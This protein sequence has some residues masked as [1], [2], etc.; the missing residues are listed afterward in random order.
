[1]NSLSEKAKREL[2]EALE[3]KQSHMFV[4]NDRLVSV[5]VENLED[6]IENNQYKD[7]SKEIESYPELKASLTR[8]LNHPEMKRYTRSELK[9]KRHEQR[10]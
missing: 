5:E 10:K 9:A 4:I 8:Y 1:M 2:Y 6:D 7:L 3:G